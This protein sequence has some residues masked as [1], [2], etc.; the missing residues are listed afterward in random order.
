MGVDTVTLFLAMLA[1][2]AAALT[3][4]IAVSALTGDRF[5]VIAAVRPVALELATAVAVTAT[6]GSLYL[7]EGAGYEPCRL[8]WVQRG[9]MYPAA[10]L[11]VLAVLRRWRWAMLAAGAL[12]AIGLPVAIF[13]RVEQAAGGIGSLCELDNP[14]SSRWVEHFGF[15]TIPTMAAVG[16]ATIMAL[17]SLVAFT[18]QNVS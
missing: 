8:C 1:A 12:A 9:F 2:L 10:I 3:L 16:F 7:S 13:H 18:P 11:L 17:V 5:G 14:C 4:V 15:V 6:A